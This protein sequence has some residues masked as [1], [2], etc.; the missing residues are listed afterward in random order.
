MGIWVPWVGT[1]WLC[2]Q[3]EWGWCGAPMGLWV[4]GVGKMEG[5]GCL[6]VF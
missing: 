3:C 2:T 5:M 6:W 4:L 1:G